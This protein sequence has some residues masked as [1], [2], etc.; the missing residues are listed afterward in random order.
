MWSAHSDVCIMLLLLT[1]N[2]SR[3]VMAEDTVHG[4]WWFYPE[5]RDVPRSNGLEVIGAG[6]PRTGTLSLHF[7]LNVLGYETYH[8]SK[9]DTPAK[10]DLWSSFY[11]G[12]VTIEQVAKQ[13]Y[14]ENGFTAAVDAP[15]ST[16][17]DKLAQLYPKAKIILTER[18]SPEEWFDS[19]SNTNLIPPFLTKYVLFVFSPFGRSFGRLVRKLWPEALNLTPKDRW[20][21]LEDR[22]KAIE[23]YKENSVAAVAFGK[24]HGRDVLLFR[25]EEGWDPLCKFLSKPVPEVPFPKTNSRHA[26]QKN[27]QYQEVA[28]TVIVIGAVIL[29]I[30]LLRRFFLTRSSEKSHGANNNGKKHK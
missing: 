5:E 7:A 24:K 21:T 13:V 30:A 12:E 16:V 18:N 3:G 2:A 27:L 23:S 17:W 25:V 4:S 1:L 10:A 26:F 22:N 20:V 28:V 29:A 15:T 11:D 19:T 9:V 14:E 6:F 8:M